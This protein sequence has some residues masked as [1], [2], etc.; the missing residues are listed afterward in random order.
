[1]LGTILAVF[2]IWLVYIV[3]VYIR[4]RFGGKVASG[5][6][7]RVLPKYFTEF[8]ET[9]GELAKIKIFMEWLWE[10]RITRR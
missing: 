2:I 10:C 5:A 7:P 3:S 1:M 9:K 8:A 4:F 6:F